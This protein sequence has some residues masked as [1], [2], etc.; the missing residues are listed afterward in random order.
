MAKMSDWIDKIHE[1]EK[2]SDS[3]KESILGKTKKLFDKLNGK[4]QDLKEMVNE[5]PKKALWSM[6][7]PS[8]FS[9][10]CLSLN[11]LVDSIFVSE[12]GSASLIGVG[13]IQSIFVIIVG[14]GAGL[15]VATN[16]SLSYAI[17]KYASRDYA[18]KIVDNSIVLTL[19]IGIILS[20]VLILILKP[21]LL[22]L[23]IYEPAIEPALI[24][25]YILFGGN[26]FFFFASVIPAILKA[27]GEITK[28]TY[29][30]ASTSLLNI[31]LDYILIH[32][33][34]YGV[35]G[36]AI[37]TVFCSALCCALLI[38]FM[39]RSK[40]IELTLYDTIFN[41]DWSI[42]K[43]IFHDSIPVTFESIILSLFG[44][45]A[46]VIF[47]LLNSPSDLAA[48]IASYK[49]YCFLIMPVV[50]IAEGNVTIVAYMFG[51]NNF[52][53]IKDLLKYE[54]K[55]GCLISGVLW[56]MVLVFN[57]Q[58]THLFVV[59]N[60]IAEIAAL[61]FAL[62]ALNILLMIMPLGL[63]S[64]SILQGIQ[65]YKESFIISTIRSVVL[66][67]LF[68]FIAVLVF[69]DVVMVY[70][71]IILGGLLGCLLASYKT[72]NIL[73]GQI[74]KKEEC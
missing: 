24:Y 8:F 2:S 39:V 28:T 14:F 41:H 59:N 56:V 11:C 1:H 22:A 29:A 18:R 21:L 71:G 13:F 30:L 53:K 58:I 74:N 6:A 44:F 55:I 25:G 49:V 26:V 23:N 62:P 70:L 34:G 16:S 15:S 48:F 42:M 50:A 37:A 32:E 51:Q 64:V 73:T 3:K 12:C 43:K 5:N 10:L 40:N 60:D 31:L 17:S 61:N 45:L 65:H 72:Q 68:G 7:I 66:E 19:I 27:T 54:V 38:F 36:A 4:S 33:L 67:I 52:E 9:L 69:H 20:I 63:I 35:F 47:N 46:N 57:N